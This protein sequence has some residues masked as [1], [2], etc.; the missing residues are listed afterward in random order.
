MPGLEARGLRQKHMVDMAWAT[1]ASTSASMSL[2]QRPASALQ[3]SLND[4]YSYT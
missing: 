1:V 3:A 2:P 4:L